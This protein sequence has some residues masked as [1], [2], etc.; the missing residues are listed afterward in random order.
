MNVQYFARKTVREQFAVFIGLFC[1]VLYQLGMVLEVFNHPSKS[2]AI[3][4]CKK[5][6]LSHAVWRATEKV[7]SRTMET[8]RK[9]FFLFFF[10]RFYCEC[11]SWVQPWG[12]SSN[13]ERCYRKKQKEITF[14]ENKTVHPVPVSLFVADQ[15]LLSDYEFLTFS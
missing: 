11:V 14:D 2:L 13:V 10:F 7:F 3:I 1:S 15:F 5:R 4:F 9:T 6:K 8:L 12:N